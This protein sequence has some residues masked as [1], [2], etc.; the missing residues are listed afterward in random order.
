MTTRTA[1]AAAA[2]LVL[3]ACS[4]GGETADKAAAVST[5]AE[6]A[7]DI[8]ASAPPA[9]VAPAEHQQVI[10]DAA[11]QRYQCDDDK[12]L[13]ARYVAAEAHAV[14]QIRYNGQTVTLDYNGESSNEDLTAFSGGGY[15]WTIGN[16]YGT[17][18]YKE[19]N[20]FLVRH[21][22]QEISGEATP[23]DNILVQ[24]CAPAA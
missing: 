8:A 1:L 12:T 20:G 16:Q 3:A 11:W 19:D 18:F 14:A 7:S 17:E 4:P 23:V 21:E 5:P 13:E 22:Q 15:T 24:N 6:T 2:L 10:N 9:D